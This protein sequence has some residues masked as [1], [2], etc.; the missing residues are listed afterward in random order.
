MQQT[1]LDGRLDEK[2]NDCVKGFLP[3]FC[4]INECICTLLSLYT[5]SFRSF[6]FQTPH[7][8]EYLNG[9]CKSIIFPNSP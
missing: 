9:R 1:V 7:A 8:G 3:F 6:H 5:L 2:L 4:L